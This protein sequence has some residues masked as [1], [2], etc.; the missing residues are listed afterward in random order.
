MTAPHL[1]LVIPNMYYVYILK[2]RRTNKLYIGVTN[3]LRRRFQEHNSGLGIYTRRDRPWTL[4]YYEAFLSKADAVKRELA[5]KNFG[6]AYGQLK[7]RIQ[8][9]LND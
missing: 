7:R 2:S 1:S 6:K 4:R 9:S 3:D 8:N 5:L